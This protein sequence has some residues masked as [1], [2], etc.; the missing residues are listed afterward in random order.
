VHKLDTFNDR[1]R[2]AQTRVRGLIGDF[3]AERKVYHLQ[4]GKRRAQ[5]LRT[6][7]DRIFLRSVGFS[8]LDRLLARLAARS[9]TL[10]S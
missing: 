3:Y 10:P 6:R 2:A 5:A 1:H 9:T 4:L 7:F 8:T